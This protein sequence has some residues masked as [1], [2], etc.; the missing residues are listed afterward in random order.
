MT[1]QV[2]EGWTLARVWPLKAA[3]EHRDGTPREAKGVYEGGD[4]WHVRLTV[5]ITPDRVVRCAAITVAQDRLKARMSDHTPTQTQQERWEALG[6]TAATRLAERGITDHQKPDAL[7]GKA[8]TSVTIGAL[9]DLPLDDMAT[10]IAAAVTLAP[11]EDWHEYMP[12][13]RHGDLL[14][15]WADLRRGKR[16]RVDVDRD[17]HRLVEVRNQGASDGVRNLTA[18]VA[19]ATGWS[20]STVQRRTREARA[21]GLLPEH[22]K[23]DKALTNADTE[24]TTERKT[25]Q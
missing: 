24:M 3:G 10:L 4:G 19:N 1:Q 22:D 14:K 13:W 20:R 16:S 15:Q 25:D 23:P 9:R 18:Y 21:A 7:P 2:R 12:H 5:T 11:Q 8:P 17:L 6:A